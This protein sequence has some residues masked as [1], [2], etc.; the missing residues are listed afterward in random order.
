MSQT[1]I[2]IIVILAVV[3]IFRESIKNLFSK[4]PTS[5][6]HEES[7][8]SSWFNL[9][10]MITKT[11]EVTKDYI[12]HDTLV[13]I[14]SLAGLL[15]LCWIIGT[16]Y[17]ALTRK[18]PAKE[19]LFELGT[20]GGLLLAL[21]G[22][23]LIILV[24]HQI[25]FKEDTMKIKPIVDVEV[26]KLRVGGWIVV[27]MSLTTR[28][29]VTIDMPHPRQY[30]NGKSFWSCPEMVSP[31]RITEPVYFEPLTKK[32]GFVNHVRI[33]DESRQLLVNYGVLQIDV[34]FTKILAGSKAEDNPCKYLKL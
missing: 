16:F 26:N 6:T 17:T 29:K 32:S 7:P 9:D 20:S 1:I 25:F 15:I 21:I 12:D 28:A 24:V 2:L 19:P 18:D 3:L 22:T 11:E 5:E 30:G 33:T 4:K 23:M 13:I 31:E 14:V 34:R 8:E 27:P 10:N